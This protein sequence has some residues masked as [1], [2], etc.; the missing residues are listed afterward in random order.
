MEFALWISGRDQDGP[1][2][3][4]REILRDV[5]IGI[6]SIIQNQNPRL[7]AVGQ[8]SSHYMRLLFQS[9]SFGNI[10]ETLLNASFTARIN[11][12][13]A[14]ESKD[15]L[16]RAPNTKSSRQVCRT[17]HDDLPRT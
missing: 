9:T 1:S 7:G 15:A 3:P 16:A 4:N 5:Q 12:E 14:P 11:P 13:Y 6:V 17:F 10:R 8:P 2:I